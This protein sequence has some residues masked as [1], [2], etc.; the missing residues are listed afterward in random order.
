MRALGIAALLA[1]IAGLSAGPS[2]QGLADVARRAAA[3]PQPPATKKYTNDDVE[4]AKPAP[5]PGAAAAAQEGAADAPEGEAGTAA[6]A[7]AST[8]AE[9]VK[10]APEPKKT[11][12]FVMNRLPKLKAQIETKEKQLRDLQ[13]R[14]AQSEAAQ[15][16]DQ[17][18]TLRRELT[19]L[20][21]SVVPAAP[22][23]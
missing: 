22:A 6:G 21:A 17:I 23:K 4:T 19:V 10:A 8:S 9:E 14:G 12:E 3:A 7:P 18:A 16:M 20:E 2:A 11:P 1:V 13:A 5:P 15:V